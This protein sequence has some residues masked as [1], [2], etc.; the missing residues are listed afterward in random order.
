M[1][2]A[3]FGVGDADIIAYAAIHPPLLDGDPAFA[4]EALASAGSVDVHASFQDRFQHSTARLNLHRYVG[5]LEGDPH[6]FLRF[7][8]YGL[9]YIFNKILLPKDPGPTVN[10]EDQ[11]L[12][13]LVIITF[14]RLAFNVLMEKRRPASLTT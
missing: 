10:M 4:A 14:G 13:Y 1:A 2:H 3:G 8:A 6:R 7:V 12:R 5:R 11:R 9:T